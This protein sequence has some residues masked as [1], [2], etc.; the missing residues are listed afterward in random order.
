MSLPLKLPWELAQNRWATDLN[1]IIKNVLIQGKLISNISI[2]I[3]SNQI[4]HLLS[5]Q[6]TGYFITD[7]NGP[8]IIYRS[9]PLNDKTLTL[10]SN[11]NCIVSI[12]MF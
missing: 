9:L 12:W 2:T 6:Q 10:T 3:G 11:A 1:P 8:A 5:K 7:I 4:N